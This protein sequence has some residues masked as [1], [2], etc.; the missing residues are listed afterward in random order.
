MKEITLDKNMVT[1]VDD[2]IYETVKHLKFSAKKAKQL[3][4]AVCYIRGKRVNLHNLV[5]GYPLP[6]YEPDH[7][8]GNSLNNQR[9][10]LRWSTCVENQRNRGPKESSH[11]TPSKSQYKGVSPVMPSNPQRNKPWRSRIK[12]PEKHSQISI[13][14]FATEIEAAIAYDNAARLYFGEFARLNFP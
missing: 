2:D 5:L 3:Y 10:N 12:I 1:Q 11:G 7:R 14:Y 13:G 4:Y 6:G 8:D 9:D